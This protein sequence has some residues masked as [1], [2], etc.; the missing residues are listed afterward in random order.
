MKSTRAKIFPAKGH[1]GL[2]WFVYI[3]FPASILHFQYCTLLTMFGRR[4]RNE[5]DDEFSYDSESDELEE[6]RH[7]DYEEYLAAF[8]DTGLGDEEKQVEMSRSEREQALRQVIVPLLA[9]RCYHLPG[10][11]W[12][13]DFFQYI[14]NNHP[15]FGICAHHRFHPI[16]AKTRIVALFGT[17]IFGLALTSVFELLYI[18]YPQY[19][20]TI[21]VFELKEGDEFVLTTAMLSLWTIGG[22]IHTGYN[23]FMWHLAA[24]VCCRDGGCLQNTKICYCP[25]FGKTFLRIFVFFILAMTLVIIALRV[26]IASEDAEAGDNIFGDMTDLSNYTDPEDFSFAL[27]YLVGMTLSFFI[28]YPVGT[29]ILFSGILGC[30]RLPVLGGRPREVRIEE[31]MNKKAEKRRM[32]KRRSQKSTVELRRSSSY[33]D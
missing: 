26:V 31:K 9:M 14:A 29:L 1:H 28:Y 8:K 32:K 7:Q 12:C 18:E 33:M 24:C 27:A 19:Q 17:L 2:F 20:R 5:T 13:R 3:S 4:K 23:L 16:G 21:W 6:F 25:S 11:S 15:V 30:Y 10:N 22:A